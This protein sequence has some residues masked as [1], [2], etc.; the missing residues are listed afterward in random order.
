MAKLIGLWLL[1]YSTSLELSEL[2]LNRLPLPQAT[3]ANSLNGKRKTE[4]VLGRLL[5]AQA[6]H[7]RPLQHQ[8]TK[9]PPN[10]QN[11]QI[12]ERPGQSPK[13]SGDNTNKFQFSISHSKGWVGLAHSQELD[14]EVLGLDIEALSE[15]LNERRAAYFCSA[16]QLA[17]ARELVDEQKKHYFT[18]LWTQKEAFFK[19]HAR[20]VLN[21]D[22]KNIDFS[23]NPHMRCQI[24]TV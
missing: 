6:L 12:H 13:V 24:I 11:W 22:T 17:S 19:A 7:D 14:N 3:R 16:Q 10:D 20:P 5:L 2:I 8:E 21:P 15:T 23:E 9:S 4:F 18:K 1:N